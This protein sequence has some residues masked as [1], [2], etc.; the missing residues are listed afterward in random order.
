MN[1]APDPPNSTTNFRIGSVAL[2]AVKYIKV[3]KAKTAPAVTTILPTI[4]DI[5][6]ISPYDN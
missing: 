6:L 1:I 3:P 4:G 2:V 5:V